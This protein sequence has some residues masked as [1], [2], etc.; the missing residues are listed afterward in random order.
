M[1]GVGRPDN[2]F[3]INCFFFWNVRDMKNLD[4]IIVFYD[5]SKLPCHAMPNRKN[6]KGIVAKTSP[7]DVQ[8]KTLP[9]PHPL[10]IMLGLALP[11][12]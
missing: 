7:L 2:A 5:V 11:F 8:L 10:P 9:V 6:Y 4:R 1:V 12:W 3:M